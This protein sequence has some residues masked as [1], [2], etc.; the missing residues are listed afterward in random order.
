M[1]RLT[2]TRAYDLYQRRCEI[3]SLTKDLYRER[4]DITEQLTAAILATDDQHLPI[5]GDRFLALRDQFAEADGRPKLK[6]WKQTCVER[7]QIIEA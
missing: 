1:A 2:K 7:W 5:G 3:D 4:D 6:V